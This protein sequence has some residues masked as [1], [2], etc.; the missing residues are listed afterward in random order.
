MFLWTLFNMFSSI[1]W[2]PFLKSSVVPELQWARGTPFLL[3]ISGKGSQITSDLVNVQDKASDL[4]CPCKRFIFWDL[5]IAK[6]LQHIQG[7]QQPFKMVCS[8]V[9]LVSLRHAPEKYFF[10]SL[11]HSV[12]VLEKKRLNINCYEQV[13]WTIF[14]RKLCNTSYNCLEGSELDISKL[15]L[16]NIPN[17]KN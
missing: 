5:G 6:I 4:L 17:G 14:K 15:W 7:K 10:V 13:D 12:I 16:C 3:A 8:L 1:V 2:K 9:V 11:S